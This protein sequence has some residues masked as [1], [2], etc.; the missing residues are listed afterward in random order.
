[1]TRIHD[2]Q[3][4]NERKKIFIEITIGTANLFKVSKQN[5]VYN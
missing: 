5:Y 4:G 1:M 3:V 2:F